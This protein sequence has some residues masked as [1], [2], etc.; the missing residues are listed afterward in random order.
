MGRGVADVGLVSPLTVK[1][2]EFKGNP[3]S[4]GMPPLPVIFNPFLATVSRLV[5]QT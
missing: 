4:G 2:R 1:L 5:W 3:G